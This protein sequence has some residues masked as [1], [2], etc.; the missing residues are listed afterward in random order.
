MVSAPTAIRS[1]D[2]HDAAAY[3]AL[4]L[5]GLRECPEAFASSS[6][7]EE[8]LPLDTVA[9]RL[10]PRAEA[11][12][13]GGFAARP[14]GEALVGIVGL[15]R[16]TMRKLAHKGWIWG[17]YVAPEARRDGLAGRLLQH[18]LGHAATA[19]GLRQVNLGVNTRNAAAQALYR[20]LGFESYGLERGF[21]LLNGELH[22][23]HQMV[24][25]L[26]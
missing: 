20:K 2:A 24:K 18:A 9:E 13:L 5:Q 11:I 23:E 3:Q 7:E 16:E 6:E 17:V 22:D 25:V 1:L 10:R 4:R 14:D 8:P 26:A 21:L 15:G 19:W 12:V